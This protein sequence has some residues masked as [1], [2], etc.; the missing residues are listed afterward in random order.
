MTTFYPS[1]IERLLTWLSCGL[2]IEC[3]WFLKCLWRLLL[4]RE[5]T[6]PSLSLLLSDLTCLSSSLTR[7]KFRRSTSGSVFAS[8]SPRDMRRTFLYLRRSKSFFL[9]R[10]LAGRK[11]LTHRTFF[12]KLES[13]QSI[14]LPVTKNKLQ[15]QKQVMSYPLHLAISCC[16]RYD[17]PCTAAFAGSG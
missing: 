15:K 8:A 4:D 17:E 12:S 1:A 7:L 14:F 9:F 3:F 6:D 2:L 10:K 5:I 16:G 11:D 13:N